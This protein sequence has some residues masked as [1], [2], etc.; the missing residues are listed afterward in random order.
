M[1]I[2]ISDLPSGLTSDPAERVDAAVKVAQR[3]VRNALADALAVYNPADA[4]LFA[5]LLRRTMDAVDDH[6]TLARLIDVS[7]ATLHR[8]SKAES[9][10]SPLER[11]AIVALLR[12]IVIHGLAEVEA[13]FDRMLE[14]VA[15]QLAL[16][17]PA[18]ARATTPRRARASSRAGVRSAVRKRRVRSASV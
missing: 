2:R 1:T 4:A 6:R 17:M 10:P 13:K 7:V 18:I 16:Q 8:W 11:A 9:A 15:A 14:A 5:R 3:T 12:T